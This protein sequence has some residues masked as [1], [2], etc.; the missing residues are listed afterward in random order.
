MDNVMHRASR[1]CLYSLISSGLL[2]SSAA[3]AAESRSYGIGLGYFYW[4]EYQPD[5]SSYVKEDGLRATAAL[6]LKWLP[7]PFA[8]LIYSGRLYGSL[9]W[10]RA[11]D[12]THIA[13]PSGH[14]STAGG[15]IGTK[16]QLTLLANHFLGQAA[17]QP[18]I[19]VAEDIWYRPLEYY[20]IWQVPSVQAGIRSEDTVCRSCRLNIGVVRT[21]GAR[22]LAQTSHSP[23]NGSANTNMRLGDNFTL[24]LALDL[25][26]ANA[27]VVRFQLEG[28]RF[29]QSDLYPQTSGIAVF[30]PRTT[31]YILGVT[32]LHP[33]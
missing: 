24:A 21:I 3:V 18:Y 20:E 12:P 23:W 31:T 4:R 1:W 33:F 2:L 32:W 5:G 11:D 22:N 16:H 9:T 14:E 27:S 28:Y 25:P 29:G 26:L 8:E 10:H 15:Q 19:A 30:Q 17:L 7:A 6:E 13:V